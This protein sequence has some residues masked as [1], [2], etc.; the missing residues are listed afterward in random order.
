MSVCAPLFSPPVGLVA[1]SCLWIAGPVLWVML[2]SVLVS[3]CAPNRLPSGHLE[4]RGYFDNSTQ[5]GARCLIPTPR[6]RMLPNL[7]HLRRGFA[8]WI[9]L[10]TN[11][12]GDCLHRDIVGSTSGVPPPLH[13]NCS[14]YCLRRDIVSSTSRFYKQILQADSVAVW[15][16]LHAN[17]S[18]YFLCQDIV[19]SSAEC[20]LHELRNH[21]R[22]RPVLSDLLG[23]L[24]EGFPPLQSLG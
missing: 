3:V 18:G 24:L 11:C 15:I 8:V 9:P 19:G 20:L 21:S 6:W 13:T 7:R 2:L 22:K 12:S 5:H 16:P 4:Y 23:R 10:H 1:V 17:C 14:G